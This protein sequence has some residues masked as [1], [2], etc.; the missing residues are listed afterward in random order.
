LGVPIKIVATEPPTGPCAPI[1]VENHVEGWLVG[2]PQEGDLA[3][4]ST[5]FCMRSASPPRRL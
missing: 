1:V 2:E 3:M 4:G 5:S